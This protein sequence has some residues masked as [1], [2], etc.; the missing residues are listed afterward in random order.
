MLRDYLPVTLGRAFLGTEKTE[1]RGDLQQAGDE[2]VAGP[3]EQLPVWGTPVLEIEE[4]VVKRSVAT[5]NSVPEA[6]SV[7]SCAVR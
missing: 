3:P 1:G 7:L 6:L 2:Q 4:D 5:G